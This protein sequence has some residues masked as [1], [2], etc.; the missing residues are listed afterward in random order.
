MADE[1]D[2]DLQRRISDEERGTWREALRVDFAPWFDDLF[3]GFQC[4][5]GWRRLVRDLSEEI[6]RIV[7]SSEAAPRLRVVQVKEKYGAL[8]YYVE[9]VP[10]AQAEAVQAAV[11]HAAA[12]SVTLC[13]HCG[14]RGRLRETQ[15]G[16]YHTACDAHVIG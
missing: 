8:R 4:A 1:F 14:A 10:P 5:D 2:R 12:R 9:N 13:E 15:E 3:W 6:A 16:I 7:G 11:E